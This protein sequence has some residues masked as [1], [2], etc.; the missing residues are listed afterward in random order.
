[1]T[2]STATCSKGLGVLVRPLPVIFE[3]LQSEEKNATFIESIGTRFKQ[4]FLKK[5]I[6]SCFQRLQLFDFKR[7]RVSLV[8]D[9][10]S[11][12]ARLVA[13]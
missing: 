8:S 6:D 7:C 3:I 5:P 10:N 11:M 9:R 13:L 1:M 12:T 4:V 2:V